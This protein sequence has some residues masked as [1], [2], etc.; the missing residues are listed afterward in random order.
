MR[1]TYTIPDKGIVYECQAESPLAALRCTGGESKCERSR[2]SN[3]PAGPILAYELFSE[4]NATFYED[5]PSQYLPVM[6]E[7]MTLMLAPAGTPR[8]PTAVSAHMPAKRSGPPTD[9]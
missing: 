1:V 3:A 8:P 6:I 4:L 5:D 2:T 7:A 9:R